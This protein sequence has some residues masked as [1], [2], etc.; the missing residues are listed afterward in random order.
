MVCKKLSSGLTRN[1]G[2]LYKDGV[3]R[4]H[5]QIKSRTFFLKFSSEF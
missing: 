3:L 2:D 1:R 5:V 4:E